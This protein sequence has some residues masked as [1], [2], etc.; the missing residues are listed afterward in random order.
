M[1]SR[2]LK[3]PSDFLGTVQAFLHT[4]PTKKK[5]AKKRAKKR[6]RKGRP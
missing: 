3:L 2:R 5:Q 4:P 6:T 1:K